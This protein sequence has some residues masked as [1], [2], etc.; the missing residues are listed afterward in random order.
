MPIHA[1]LLHVTAALSAAAFV[2]SCPAA[3]P[4]VG[5]MAPDFVGIDT[6]DRDTSLTT[7]RGKVVVV[8]FWASWCGPCLKE[9]PILERIQETAGK[10]QL[11]VIAVNTESREVYRRAA[12]VLGSFELMLNFDAGKKSSASYG[13]NGIPHMIIIDR[14]GRIVRIHHGYNEE[15][16]DRIIADINRALQAAD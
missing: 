9:M 13:V 10:D 2:A 14:G 4:K 11:Q 6:E 12:K 5:E 15:S 7:F 8:S 1:R 16:L 3:V